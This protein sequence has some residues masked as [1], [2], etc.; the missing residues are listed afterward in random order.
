MVI[1]FEVLE[2]SMFSVDV[3]SS[4]ILEPST[5]KVPST[6]VLSR[7]VVPSTSKSPAKVSVAQAACRSLLKLHLGWLS[8]Q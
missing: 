7:L 2:L 4:E 6:S 3:E 5:T 1:P 8:S